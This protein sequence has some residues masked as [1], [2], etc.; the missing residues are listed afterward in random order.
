MAEFKSEIQPGPP[1]I[2]TDCS[3]G[4]YD[5]E[6]HRNRVHVYLGDANTPLTANGRSSFSRGQQADS[7]S[8]VHLTGSI[9]HECSH[10]QPTRLQ[11]MYISRSNELRKQVGL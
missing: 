7:M 6:S 10:D 5:S 3:I 2:S 8:Q 4:F 1:A 11:R 9:A